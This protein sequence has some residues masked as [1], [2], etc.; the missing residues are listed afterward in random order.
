MGDGVAKRNIWVVQM[1]VVL[2]NLMIVML[3][4]QT[5][6]MDGQVTKRPGVASTRV[7][8]AQ[9]RLA[10]RHELSTIVQGYSCTPSSSGGMNIQFDIVVCQPMF[11]VLTR[12]THPTQRYLG[13][14]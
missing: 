14:I 2:Q 13:C 3:D 6:S 11:A 9:Q 4:T 5:G 10:P 1:L 12:L 8:D 7:A